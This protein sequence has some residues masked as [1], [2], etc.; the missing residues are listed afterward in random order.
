MG[1]KDKLKNV[2]KQMNEDAALQTYAAKE[3][4]TLGHYNP[5]E[6]E[7][8]ILKKRNITTRKWMNK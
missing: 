8:K 4:V 5:N 2:W 3:V 6:K 1:V 7:K